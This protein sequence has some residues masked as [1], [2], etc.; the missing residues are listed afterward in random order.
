[1]VPQAVGVGLKVLSV[2]VHRVLVPGRGSPGTSAKVPV[3]A[4]QSWQGPDS[5]NTPAAPGAHPEPLLPTASSTLLL[6]TLNSLCP[7]VLGRTL[8]G[9]F[10]PHKYFFHICK[11]NHLKQAN[12]IC[13]SSG[14]PFC[15]F[16]LNFKSL[17]PFD[18]TI[19]QLR[20]LITW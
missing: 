9:L 18:M 2:L 7:P 17:L 15:L 14:A 19:N 11:K 1:M 8:C 5:T 6:S 12:C 4:V 10:S 16:S 20:P 13:S 3:P